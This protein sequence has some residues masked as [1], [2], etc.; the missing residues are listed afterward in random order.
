MRN[1]VTAERMQRAV[2]L[3]SAIVLVA[4]GSAAIIK[5]VD[6]R[7]TVS[8]SLAQEHI[9]GQP[10]MTPKGIAARASQAG[11][12]GVAFPDCSV[13]G[14]AIDD[15]DSARCFSQYM[16]VDALMVT[17]GKTYAQMPAFV[18]KDG[19]L[20][21]DIAQAKTLPNGAPVG[22]P[23]REVWVTQ[24]ALATALTTSYMA[25]QISLFGIAVGVAL[26]LIGIV[27]GWLAI[28]GVRI[29]RAT[30]TRRETVASS[31]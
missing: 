20:T 1:T 3:S 21:N 4:I 19:K 22:N 10:F 24:T 28:A 14:K 17:G 26:L 16:R 23:A 5:G 18:A 13:A 29:G 9:V 8:D 12:K 2:A 7:S 31:T 27:L 25:A 30:D 15:G 11:L 6:G